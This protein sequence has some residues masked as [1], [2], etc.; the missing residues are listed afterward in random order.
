MWQ[1]NKLLVS[2]WADTGCFVP[3]NGILVIEN[4]WSQGASRSR[5]SLSEKSEEG[6]GDGSV[7]KV[8]TWQVW[9]LEFRSLEPTKK[10]DHCG[11]PPKIPVWKAEMG[12]PQR[13]WHCHTSHIISLWAQLRNPLSIS[14]IESNGGRFSMSTWGLHIHACTPHALMP[15][16]MRAHTHEKNIK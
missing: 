2:F 6:W 11:D 4:C 13:K 7:T 9:G 15:A 14:K 12:D 16:H 3:L 5:D 10:V 8:F 1:Q